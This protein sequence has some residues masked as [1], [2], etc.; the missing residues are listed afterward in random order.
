[1]KIEAQSAERTQEI[2]QALGQIVAAGD[3]I[4]LSGP[5]GAGK[6]TFVQGLARGMGV[7]GRVTS[8]TFVISHVHEGDPDLIHVDAYRL[9]SL[10]EVDG[11]DLDA[12]LSESVTV[13]EWGQGKIEGLADDRLIITIVRPEGG[14]AGQDV[15]DLFVDA[16]REMIFEGTGP[17]SAEI[18]AALENAL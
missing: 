16:G 18:I 8:P 3:L 2:G 12:S 14:E 13:V 1:M 9:E 5:L 4:M 6:T 17:R 11:L 10:D 15:A 7:K